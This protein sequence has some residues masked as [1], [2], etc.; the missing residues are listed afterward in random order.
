[1][2]E[3]T[4]KFLDGCDAADEICP[5]K[6]G[7]HQRDYLRATRRAIARVLELRTD[8]SEARDEETD[9]E[10]KTHL[11]ELDQILGALERE[12]GKLGPQLD[13]FQEYLGR[14]KAARVHVRGGVEEV[15]EKRK[16]E[17]RA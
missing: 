2:H 4:K 12:A 6:T 7:G 15:V 10:I 9:P 11:A 1:M 14:F 8:F 17:R 13:R 3:S 16:R 5:K